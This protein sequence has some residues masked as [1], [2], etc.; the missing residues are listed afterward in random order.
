MAKVKTQVYFEP[1]ELEGLHRVA[2]KKKRPVAALIREAV[3]ERWL[4]E[5]PEGPVALHHGSLR[6][7]AAD[8]DAA[9]DEL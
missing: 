6:A 4:T 3:R 8:H 5:P 9:F 7:N 1:A 2:R